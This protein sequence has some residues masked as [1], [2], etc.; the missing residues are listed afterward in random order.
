MPTNNKTPNLNLNNWLGTDKPKRIDFFE[1]NE[2]LDTV[3]SS[4]LSDTS[5]HITEEEKKN[6]SS[7]PVLGLLPGNGA[8]SRTHVL[9]FN[10]SMVIVFLR[11]TI[12]NMYDPVNNYTICNIGIAVPGRGSTIGASLDGNELTLSQTQGAPLDGRFINLNTTHGQYVYIAF[13]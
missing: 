1:N 6:L 5:M 4:H 8:A 2:I 9:N 7:G 11:N 12:F 10:P 3:I 13:N